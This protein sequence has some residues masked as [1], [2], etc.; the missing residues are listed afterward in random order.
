M[1]KSILIVSLAS[2]LLFESFLPNFMSITQ[3][4]KMGE[5]YSHFKD[6]NKAGVSLSEFLWMH[7]A[8]ESSHKSN[9]E[10]Q[11]LPSI[12]LHFGFLFYIPSF[13]VYLEK[14]SFEFALLGNLDLNHYFNNYHFN[15]LRFL[16]NPPQFN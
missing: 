12:N 7:Y 9:A 10:H 6:H 5:L 14:I 16:L 11:K 13:S 3:S 8:A 2:L 1:I 15:Y 4:A